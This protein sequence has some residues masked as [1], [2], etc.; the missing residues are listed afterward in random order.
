MKYKI[1]KIALAILCFTL[2]ISFGSS[3]L[4][5]L[6]I[7]PT[8]EEGQP[9]SFNYTFLSETDQEISYLIL[10]KCPNAPISL[11]QMENATLS[12]RIPFTKTYVYL[13][14]VTGDVP[15]QTCEANVQILSPATVMATK[16]FIINTPPSFDFYLNLCKDPSCFNQSKIFTKG[17][18]VYLDYNSN[19]PDL[20]VLGKLTFPNEELINFSLPTSIYLEQT[21]EY[22]L[23]LNVLKAG[24]RDYVNE[25]KFAVI[26][27]EANIPYVP[28]E[29]QVQKNRIVDYLISFIII[30]II[31]IVVIL[32]NLFLKRKHRNLIKTKK[33]SLS[34]PKKS[35]KSNFSSKRFFANFS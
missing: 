25:L 14:N 33:I 32:W 13:S 17:E 19:L 10:T 24:Y 23:S 3:V 12:A 2:I 30:C 1:Q 11:I 34:K 35:K 15:P 31:I 21:G 28:L 22:E 9:I 4:I 20:T 29:K 16:T 26:D 5:D 27:K 18:T 8:F 6:T 7:N